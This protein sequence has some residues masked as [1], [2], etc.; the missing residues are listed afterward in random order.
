MLDPQVVVNLLPELR[1]SV[2]LMRRVR[3]LGSMVGARCLV[4]L[5]VS[6]R[7]LDS[8]TNQVHK[9]LSIFGLIAPNPHGT[10]NHPGELLQKPPRFRCFK[11]PDES[12]DRVKRCLSEVKLSRPVVTRLRVRRDVGLRNRNSLRDLRNLSRD[13]LKNSLASKWL[14]LAQS[15]LK[16]GSTIAEREPVAEQY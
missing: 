7:T 10:T 9:R 2:D 3:W 13:F 6:V 11:A 15:Y 5:G 16:D 14:S 8:E 12:E 1:V 4:P